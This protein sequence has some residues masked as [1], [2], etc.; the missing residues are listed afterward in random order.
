[1]TE[2]TVIEQLR[3]STKFLIDISVMESHL[4]LWCLD[5]NKMSET[6]AYT[7]RL[8]SHH[9]TTLLPSAWKH[10]IHVMTYGLQCLIQW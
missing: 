2:N 10:C 9:E 6:I 1:M 4:E 3:F 7:F 5:L 8:V